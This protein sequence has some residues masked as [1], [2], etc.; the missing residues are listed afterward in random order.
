M[1]TLLFAWQVDAGAPLVV[2]ANRDE[3]HARPTAP[4]QRWAD[5]PVFAGRDLL[6]GG[7]WL[8]VA[9]GGRFAALTNVR[10]PLVPAPLDARSRGELVAGFLRGAMPPADYLAGLD[11]DAYPGFNLVVADARALWYLSNRA[12]PARA[13]DP[14]VYGISNAGLDTPWPKVVRGRERLTALVAAGAADTGALLGLLADRAPAADAELPDTGVG[15]A[16]ERM[17][18]PLCIVGPDY[19]TRCSTALRILRDGTVEFHERSL[20]PP[21]PRDVAVTLDAW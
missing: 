10:E 3:F 19:G 6:A 9:P 8:G 11:P 18:S 4:A 14:G 13:L 2:A 15:S 16:L 20:G 5:A 7:T 1:C 21:G 12:G 17:L